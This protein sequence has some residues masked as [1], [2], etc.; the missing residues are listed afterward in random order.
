MLNIIGS[1]Y[2][3]LWLLLFA[4]TPLETGLGFPEAADELEP[5]AEVEEALALVTAACLSQNTKPS[6]SV[7]SAQNLKRCHVT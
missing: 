3:L 6:F 2:L 5:E 7:Q 1:S 4:L